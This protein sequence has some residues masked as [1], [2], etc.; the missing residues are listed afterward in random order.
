MG[1]TGN[2]GYMGWETESMCDLCDGKQRVYV[3][4]VMGNKVYDI[5]D[6][7]QSMCALCDGKHR[8]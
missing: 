1:N 8:D 6:G 4:Y 7:K 2:D 3:I 5:C